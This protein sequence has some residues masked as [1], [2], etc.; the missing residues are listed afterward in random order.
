MTGQT[1]NV[2]LEK[3]ICRINLCSLKKTVHKQDR[4]RAVSSSPFLM[5]NLQWSRN[6]D[7]APRT[8][9]WRLFIQHAG[10]FIKYLKGFM[11]LPELKN[12]PD[13]SL[14]WPVQLTL[15]FDFPLFI[16]PLKRK[17]DK[18]RKRFINIHYS[19]S[20]DSQV[21]RGFIGKQHVYWNLTDLSWVQII[22]WAGEGNVETTSRRGTERQGEKLD[23]EA[24]RSRK[25][26]KKQNKT[27]YVMSSHREAAEPNTAVSQDEWNNPVTQF[28]KRFVFNH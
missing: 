18:L 21:S 28:F 5:S 8:S 20:H 27:R 17:G 9:W 23:I 14:N 2:K 1:K 24:E 4:E 6:S 3:C 13:L 26:G 22:S 19:L 11:M 12:S 16:C 7:L 10:Q 15:T 25:M